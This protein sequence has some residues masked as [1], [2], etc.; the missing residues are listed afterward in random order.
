MTMVSD[1]V[2]TNAHRFEAGVKIP[3]TFED[4]HLLDEVRVT[5]V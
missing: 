3:E 4:W 5:C 2:T 1:A